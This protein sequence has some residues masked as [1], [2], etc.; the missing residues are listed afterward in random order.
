MRTHTQ[1]KSPVCSLICGSPGYP[2]SVTHSIEIHI[3]WTRN[4][5]RTSLEVPSLL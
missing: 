5:Y 3:E 2:I 4:K 1:K